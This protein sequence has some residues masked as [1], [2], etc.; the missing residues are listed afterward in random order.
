MLENIA[1]E[2]Y[3]YLQPTQSTAI[4]KCVNCAFLCMRENESNLCHMVVFA[5]LCGA[6]LTNYLENDNKR[7]DVPWLISSPLLRTLVV[8]I[9]V[10]KA[11]YNKIYRTKISV[12]NSWSIYKKFSSSIVN[13]L[14][15]MRDCSW[16]D[17][18]EVDKFPRIGKLGCPWR[19]T[20]VEFLVI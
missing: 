18:F 7:N 1:M 9:L 13:N 5:I 15:R 8:R 12:W 6:Y 3:I 20:I 2:C 19:S 4:W 17:D 16:V 11:S 10:L 14:Q